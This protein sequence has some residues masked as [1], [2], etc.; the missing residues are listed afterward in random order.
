[1]STNAPTSRHIMY[2]PYYVYD[3]GLK[4]SLHFSLNFSLFFPQINSWIRSFLFLKYLFFTFLKHYFI[5]SP[6]LPLGIKWRSC[7]SRKVSKLNINFPFSQAS[8]LSI[9]PHILFI[10]LFFIIYI[11]LSNSIDSLKPSM[12][13]LVPFFFLEHGVWSCMV[14]WPLKTLGA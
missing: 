8:P 3:V 5:F 10:F 4:V 12:K 6:F 1:M 13:S 14:H 7:V 2:M 11:K 9:Y